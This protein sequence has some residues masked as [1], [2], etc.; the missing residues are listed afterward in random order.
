MLHTLGF[1]E[2]EKSTLVLNAK[3]KSRVGFNRF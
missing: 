3:H 1:I 2:E